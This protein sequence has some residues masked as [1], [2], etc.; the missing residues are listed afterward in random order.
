[1]IL[2]LGPQ[3]TDSDHQRDG[4]QRHT[5]GAD[6]MVHLSICSSLSLTTW[7]A[8]K[9][10]RALV[11]PTFRIRHSHGAGESFLASF[12]SE[13]SVLYLQAAYAGTDLRSPT[14]SPRLSPLVGASNAIE[15]NG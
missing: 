4:R 11:S 3:N 8:T 2:Q 15:I 12:S 9:A 14:A 13:M 6:S 1:M 10:R 5:D 7:A